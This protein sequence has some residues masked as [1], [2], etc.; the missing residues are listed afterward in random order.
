MRDFANTKRPFPIVHPLPFALVVP[1][2]GE[3]VGT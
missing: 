2:A 3:P 1:I